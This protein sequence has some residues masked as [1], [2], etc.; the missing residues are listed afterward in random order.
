M[1]C[2]IFVGE[3]AKIF[4]NISAQTAFIAGEIQGNMKVK[5]GLE[6]T[7]TAKVYGDIKTRTLV[8]AQ[9][10]IFF[11]KCSAGEEKKAKIEKMEKDK[12]SKYKE[13]DNVEENTNIAV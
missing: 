13:M 6:L 8:V 7:Q 11:G 12:T 2:E 9:G 5:E 3:N 1:L 10:A 4:A